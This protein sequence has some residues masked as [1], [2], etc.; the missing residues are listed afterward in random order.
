MSDKKAFPFQIEHDQGS[1]REKQIRGNAENNEQ[2]SNEA[3]SVL[4][5]NKDYADVCWVDLK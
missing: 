3:L 4:Q 5:H 2:I 1:D